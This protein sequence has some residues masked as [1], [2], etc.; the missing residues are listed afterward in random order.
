VRRATLAALAAAALVAVPAAAQTTAQRVAAL[1]AYV[2]KAVKDWHAPG[3]AIAVVKDDSVIFAKGYG[4]RELGKPDPVDAGTRFAIGSTTKAMTV[5]ALG[6]LVDEGRL[7]WDDPV[8]K[9][10][11]EFRLSDPYVTREITIRDLLTHR[12]GLG[13]ADLLWADGEYSTAEIVRRVGFLPLAY[14]MRSGWVY[15]NIM[16]AVAGQVVERV[17]GMPWETFLRTRIFQPLGMTATEP[18]LSGLAGQPNVASPHAEEGDTMRLTQNRSVDP[19][20][21]AGSVWSSVGDMARWTRFILDSGRVGGRRLLKEATFREMLTPQTIADPA[22]YE[23][24]ALIKPHFITYGLGWF[25]HDYRGQAVAMHTGSINGMSAIIGLIPDQR[26]GV[27]VLA[28][29]DHV[30]LR[31]ALMLEVFDRFT[32]QPP[33]NWSA[34]LLTLYGGLREQAVAA[35]RQAEQRRATD[36]HPSLPLARYAGTYESP[37]YGRVVVTE[38]GGALRLQFGK[39]IG[40][41]SHWQYDTFQSRWTDAALSRSLV[42]FDPD[43]AGNVSGVRAFGATFTRQR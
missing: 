25:L 16:Y 20:K 4:V 38:Q 7:R 42:V 36:T 31:H 29:G 6:M 33:Q 8:T 14:S 28:N 39:R 12:A 32:G 2:A 34:R 24:F 13:N 22:I 19:V 26:L 23:T 5:V 18:L 40:D 17:S 1:D 3:L 41:L 9:H 35:Q 15:Q 27:Y 10:L 21:A 11:P 30:E 37:T 43:G